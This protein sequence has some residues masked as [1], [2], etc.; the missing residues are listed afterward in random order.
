[1]AEIAS[2]KCSNTKCLL[3]FLVSSGFP[4]WHPSTP[5]D[6]KSLVLTPALMPYV[7][8]YHNE[9]FC[10]HCKKIVAILED[11]ACR[12]CGARDLALEQAG[13]HCP[14]CAEGVFRMT[15]LSVY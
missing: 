7:V 14:R 13:R 12:L 6:I 2:Y 5:N 1:M 3:T 4:I 11:G 15:A 8:G 10:Q 9:S